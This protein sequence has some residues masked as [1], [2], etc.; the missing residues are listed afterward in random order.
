V[1]IGRPIVPA[2]FTGDVRTRT[3][4]TTGELSR[5]MQALLPGDKPHPR[6][7]LLRRWLTSLF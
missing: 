3:T 7:R 1:R 6:V 5:R 4:E 2:D